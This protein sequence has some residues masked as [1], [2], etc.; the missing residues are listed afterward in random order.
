MTLLKSAL[1]YAEYGWPVLPVSPTKGPCCD[2][3]VYSATVDESTIKQ[4]WR[5][6]PDAN[7][8]TV[9]KEWLVL[10]IDPRNGG[11]QTLLEL[12]DKHGPIPTT[13][14]ART[15]GGGVHY[16]FKHPAGLSDIPLGPLLD[17][18]DIKG[19]GKHYVLVPPSRSKSGVYTWI[20]SPRGPLAQ[21]PKWLFDLIVELK[22]VRVSEP[23]ELP[24][25]SVCNV[26]DRAVRYADK[27]DLAI[28]GSGGQSA[29]WSAA[30][31][32]ARG[33]A[34]SESDAVAALSSWNMRCSPPWSEGDLRRAVRR[35][36]TVAKTPALGSLLT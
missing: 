29:L 28:S 31:K 24:R 16:Y 36:L 13:W 25:D 30:L 7:I 5:E 26:L 1:F 12:L 9:C 35:A 34:L 10:D 4:W 17:G 19:N 15:G 33:F 21:C 2:H 18:I 8:A 11:D 27:L 32:V 23:V 20:K 14:T 22:T 6:T 3:G